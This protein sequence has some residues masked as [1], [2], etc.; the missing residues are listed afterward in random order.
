MHT[1]LV[2]VCCRDVKPRNII[3][4]PRTKE[5]RLIDWGLA[6]FYLPGRRY[7]VRVG[8]RYYKAPELLCGYRCVIADVC[9]VSILCCATCH[10]QQRL[11]PLRTCLQRSCRFVRTL[12]SQAHIAGTST[13]TYTPA[14]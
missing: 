9:A 8:S 2:A 3:I 1:L 13:Y 10:A 4:N 5:L 7:V 12:H 6:D 11:H 14:H